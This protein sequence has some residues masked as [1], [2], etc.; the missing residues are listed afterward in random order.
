MSLFICFN[1][2]LNIFTTI[3]KKF[4]YTLQNSYSGRNFNLRQY[5][6]QI[7]SFIDNLFSNLDS[8]IE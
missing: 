1:R 7:V 6:L 4:H 5:C 8:K 2:Y 3:L